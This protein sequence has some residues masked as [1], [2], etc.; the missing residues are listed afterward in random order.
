MPRSLQRLLS[1]TSVHTVSSLQL[2]LPSSTPVPKPVH[3]P[4]WLKSYCSLHGAFHIFT[5]QDVT[6]LRLTKYPLLV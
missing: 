1:P 3:F 6:R 2:T 4:V 5:D